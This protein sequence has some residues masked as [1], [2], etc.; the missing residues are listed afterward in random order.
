MRWEVWL[1]SGLRGQPDRLWSRRTP[2]A[3]AGQQG[4]SPEKTE[5]GTGFPVTV[6]SSQRVS[7]NTVSI[8]TTAAWGRDKSRGGRPAGTVNTLNLADHKQT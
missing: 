2:S 1:D 8:H 5:A 4:S 3:G 7:G 6:P